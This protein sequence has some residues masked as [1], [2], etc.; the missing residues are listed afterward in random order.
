SISTSAGP[1]A[2][3]TIT[4][5]PAAGSE[6]TVSPSARGSSATWARSASGS[7]RVAI[8]A[9]TVRASATTSAVPA[10]SSDRGRV[11]RRAGSTAASAAPSPAPTRIPAASRSAP[12]TKWPPS[13]AQTPARASSAT[14]APSAV[15][16]SIPPARSGAVRSWLTVALRSP[17]GAV[18]AAGGLL[19]Q[20]VE[21][22]GVQGV[23]DAVRQARHEAL[24]VDR[25]QGRGER[26]LGPEQ[27][28]HVGGGVVGA[29][30]AVAVLVDGRELA[31]V[32]GSGEVHAA[33]AGV[34]RAV[35][36]HSG[37][38][39][40]VGGVGTGRD[41]DEQVVDRGDAE[42]VARPGLRQLVGHP[43]DDGAE[44]LLLQRPSDAEAVEGPAVLLHRPEVAGRLP[45]Q[46]LV[47]GALD[48]APQLLIGPVGALGGQAGVLGQ[49]A[50]R[51]PAG[52]LERLLLVAAGVHQGGQLVEGEHDVRPQP[53]LDL[54]RDLGREAVHVAVDG[55][56]E[57]DAVVGDVGQAFLALGAVVVFPG[58]GACR[59]PAA[60]LAREHLAEAG[61]QAHL[62]EAAGVGVGGAG[63]VHEGTQAAGLVD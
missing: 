61:A 39:D 42:Q 32:P 22:A 48:H 60:E 20:G 52:A 21:V 34:D 55:G 6:C 31:A 14:A 27:M 8:T 11:A 40:A 4:G 38:G 56:A 33:G 12:S 17:R 28:V 46:V 37:G 36:R 9:G 49:A 63:P 50:D 45:A 62:L 23:A 18:V 35:A 25:A 41:R 53:V 13:S 26:L 1:S 30:V 19:P 54:H 10:A 43:A 15:V 58:G 24:V 7:T 29:G 16:R 3:R 57:G 47:L 51:P 5:L 2:R 59:L 44:V